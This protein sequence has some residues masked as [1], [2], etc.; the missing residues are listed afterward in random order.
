LSKITKD[1]IL[2]LNIG[3]LAS[4]GRVLAVRGDQAKIQLSKPV[5]A[6]ISDKL[7]LS[8]RIQGHFR[9]IGWGQ[10]CA[11]KELDLPSLT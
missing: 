5:C 4:H 8:R 2:L 9:L 10:I 7:A 11:G 3:S 1:E 6:E